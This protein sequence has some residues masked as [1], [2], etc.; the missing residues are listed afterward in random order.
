MSFAVFSVLALAFA[1]ASRV[2]KPRSED[3]ALVVL[4]EH[5]RCCWLRLAGVIGVDQQA[6]FASQQGQGELRYRGVGENFIGSSHLAP[7]RVDPAN[8][9]DPH[10]S[11]VQTRYEVR[12]FG[13]GGSE[14][15]RAF[16]RLVHQ[17]GPGPCLAVDRSGWATLL[18]ELRFGADRFDVA[19]FEELRRR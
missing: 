11:A 7:Y 16:E 6:S 2:L 18:L 13:A 12:Q 4:P 3:H 15:D 1:F 19:L 17:R 9:V 8:N 14:V 5:P 10:A